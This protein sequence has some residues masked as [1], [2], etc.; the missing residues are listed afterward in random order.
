MSYSFFPY[1]RSKLWWD[2]PLRGV[3]HPYK[4]SD[5]FLARFGVERQVWNRK[6]RYRFV[7]H[8]PG[9]YSKLARKYLA[10]LWY[11]LRNGRSSRKV[12]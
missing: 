7:R 3:R 10:E 2:S 11:R 4:L 6:A 12:Y 9:Y 5:R 1:G 8:R